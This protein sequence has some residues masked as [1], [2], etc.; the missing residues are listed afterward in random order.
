VIVTGPVFFCS[1]LSEQ[2]RQQGVRHIAAALS[3]AA[4]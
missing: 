4:E 3:R 2:W 1:A